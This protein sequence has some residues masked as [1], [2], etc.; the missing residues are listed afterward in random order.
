MWKFS[1]L[2]ELS[3]D[4]YDL[5]LGEVARRIAYHF[6]F[7]VEGKQSNIG[8]YSSKLVNLS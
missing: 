6:V 1:T 5:V 2:I 8:H 4:G 7:F 3:R